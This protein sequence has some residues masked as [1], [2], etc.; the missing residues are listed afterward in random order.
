MVAGMIL[1]AAAGAAVAIDRAPVQPRAEFLPRVELLR[2]GEPRDPAAGQPFWRVRDGQLVAY[3]VDA[4]PV[5]KLAPLSVEINAGVHY[6]FD[7][8]YSTGRSS[9]LVS[10]SAPVTW[11]QEGEK[12]LF[13]IDGSGTR[14][15]SDGATHAVFSPDGRYVAITTRDNELK[16]VDTAG[17]AITVV[18]AAAMPSWNADGTQVVFLGLAGSN[19]ELP[20]TRSIS[21]IDVA[22]GTV[23]PLT[24]HDHDDSLPTFHPSGQWVVFVSGDRTGT[25]S[26]WAV[27]TAGGEPRQLTNR[28]LS[29]PELPAIP[30][31][32]Q[33]PQWSQ[34]GHWLAFDDVDAGIGTVW[35]IEF[36]DSNLEVQRA[37]RI[38][39]GENP[40]W[41]DDGSVLAFDGDNGPS[42]VRLGR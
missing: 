5:S 13:L 6:L 10:L 23:V 38:G 41:L 37:A 29:G 15:L 3:S 25:A 21:L 27:P 26:L 12:D 39:R 19:S 16:I 14:R 9:F 17:K 31:P 40:V 32:R 36:D 20:E 33:L 28:H 34:D 24:N 42:Y 30:P 2:L 22:T 7:W 4:K 18:Q 11:P 1:A 8:N 35:V